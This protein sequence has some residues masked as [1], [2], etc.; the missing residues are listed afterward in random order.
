MILLHHKVRLRSSGMCMRNIQK[1]FFGKIV[2]CIISFCTAQ[3]IGIVNN[4]Q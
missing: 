3:H 1:R 4:K 2:K